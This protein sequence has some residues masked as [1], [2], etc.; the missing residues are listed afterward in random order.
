MPIWL[1]TSSSLEEANGRPP[2][3][4]IPSWLIV[5]PFAYNPPAMTEDYQ[6]TWRKQYSR[7]NADNL[8][9]EG[10]MQIPFHPHVY[11]HKSHPIVGLVFLDDAEMTALGV[12]DPPMFDDL[13]KIHYNDLIKCC[14]RV[15]VNFLNKWTL[16]FKSPVMMVQPKHVKPET[17]TLTVQYTLTR[18][19]GNQKYDATELFRPA[20]SLLI[21]WIDSIYPQPIL[22]QPATAPYETAERGQAR[23]LARA[24]TILEQ[25]P[26]AARA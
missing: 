10:V 8:E 6:E 3:F 21:D 1:A 22:E 4:L 13:Y 26:P 7:W 15:R 24:M 20:L 25:P 12:S 14:D 18:V 2:L 23:A 11:V 16:T 5:R 19:G 17:P 9:K